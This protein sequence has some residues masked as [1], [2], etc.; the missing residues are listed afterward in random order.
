MD[1]PKQHSYL[2][3]DKQHKGVV[4]PGEEARRKQSSTTLFGSCSTQQDKPKTQA[5]TL[6]ITHTVQGKKKAGVICSL[7][8]S[9]SWNFLNLLLHIFGH[10]SPPQGR[11]QARSFLLTLYH[12]HSMC[13]KP[14]LLKNQQKDT[15]IQT[16]TEGKVQHT[17][18]YF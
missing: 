5:H 12:C 11:M 14:Q 4:W 2:V 13:Q 17:F 18:S 16:K 3:Q 1:F 10:I 7:T 8:G 15:T 6:P 9:T